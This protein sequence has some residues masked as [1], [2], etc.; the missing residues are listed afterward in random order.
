LKDNIKQRIAG[1]A[2]FLRALAYFNLIRVFGDVP[3]VT[4]E[5]KTAGDAFSYGRDD[6]ETVFN[7]IENELATSYT[8]LPETY[9]SDNLGRATSIAAKSLLGK[10][11]LTRHKYQQSR[12]IL[13]E[14]INSGRH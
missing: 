5:I 10:V 3:L 14:V 4:S 6:M 1:E 9:T 2:M 8:L 13:A 12:E 7:F 11:Y